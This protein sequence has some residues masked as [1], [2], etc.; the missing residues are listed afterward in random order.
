MR[1]VVLRC[2]GYNE[3]GTAIIEAEATIIRDVA[4]RVLDGDSLRSLV[5]D[6]RQREI[7]T[8]GR[9]PFS[10]QTL[11]RLLRNPRLAG[12]R[13]HKG[14]VVGPGTWPAILDRDTHDRLLAL[15]TDPDRQQP[16]ATNQRKYL[17]TGLLRCAND[18]T[19]EDGGT[20]H[21][22]DKPLY[23]QPSNSGKRGYVCRSGSP[24]YGCGRIRIG[25]EALEEEIAARALARLSTPNLRARL[26]VGAGSELAP[27]QVAARLAVLDGRLEEAGTQFARGGFSLVTLKAIE[28]EVR[29]ERQAMLDAQAQTERLRS[30]PLASPEGLAMWWADASVDQ[31]REM[32]H[33]VLDHINVKPAT[34]LG[35]IR[36]D[37]QRIEIVWR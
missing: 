25:A 14:E 24:S 37:E 19:D 22:C 1:G 29:R 30:V 11:S 21:R 13:T 34:R 8:S 9:R 7:L 32:L 16:N 23:T 15:L 10:Q 35:F 27:E 5:A 31:R 12:L 20:P 6:L 26:E 28:E 17:L 3:G 33:L 2:Y 4:Q 36:F 18:L